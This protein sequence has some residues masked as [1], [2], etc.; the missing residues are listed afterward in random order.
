MKKFLLLVLDRNAYFLLAAAWLFT[1]AFIISNYYSGATSVGYLRS[2]MEARVRKQEERINKLMADTVQLKVLAEGSFTGQQ[3]AKL[4]KEEF[5]FF[6]YKPAEHE[7]WS[8]QFWSNQQAEPNTEIIFS[9]DSHHLVKLRNGQYEYIRRIIPL[10]RDSLLAIA[11]LPIRTEYF[12]Q[13]SAPEFMGFPQAE[14]NVSIR[15]SETSY[16]VRCANGQALFYLEQKRTLEVKNA[17]EWSLVLEILA[18]ALLMIVVHSIATSVSEQYGFKWGMLFLLAAILLARGTTYL[19][20]NH[21]MWK[22][23]GLFDPSVYSSNAF[24]PSLGDLVINAFLFCWLLLFFYRKG[25]SVSVARWKHTWL[26]WPVVAVIA[27]LMVLITFLFAGVVQSLIS[28]AQISFNV[29]NIFSLNGYS[30]VGFILL[31]VLA[32]SFSLATSILMRLVRPL[33]TEK[34]YLFYAA[35]ALFG[36][37]S[38]TFIGTNSLVE[39]NIYVLAWLIGYVWLM[40]QPKISVSTYRWSISVLLLWIFLYSVSIS[41]IIINENSRI[42]LDKRRG[43]AEKLSQQADPTSER[44]LSIALT[45]FDNDFL[46]SNFQRFRVSSANRYLKDSLIN[47][48]F[49]PYISKYDT[50]IYT[51]DEQEKPL[52]NEEP[53]SYDTLNTIFRIEGKPT[54]LAD[55]RYFEKSFDQFSYISRKMVTDSMG[56][57][58]GYVF[59]LS[60]PKKYKPDA[61]VPALFRARKDYLPDDYTP[62]Y[63]Y[64]IYNNRELIDYYNDYP[65][66]TKLGVNQVPKNSFTLTQHNGYDELWYRDDNKVVVIARRDNVLMESITLVAYLF[67]TFLLLLGL[68]RLASLLMRSRMRL[69]L[70]KK[71]LQMNLRAQ[72]H[73]TI[74]FISLFS[75]LV[76]GA[77]TIFFFI[78]RYNNNKQD[79]LSKAIKIMANEVQGKIESEVFLEWMIQLYAQGNNQVLEELVEEMSEIHGTDINIYDLRGVL[80]LSS[81]PFIYDKGILSARMNPTAFYEL[82]KQ[83]LVQVTTEEQMGGITYQ[84]IYSP[85][86]DD[87]GNAYAYLN[88]PS[89]DSQEELKKEISNFLVTIINLNAFIFLFA[90]VVALFITNRVTSSFSLISAKMRAVSLGQHN[91]AIEW[92][93]EDEIGELVTEYNKMV[94]KLEESAAALAKSERESAWREMARQVA[95]EIKNPL[96][97]MKLSIQYLQKAVNN[98]SGD[99]KQLTAN[100]ANTLVEQIDHLSRIASEFSQFANINNANVEVFDLH[101]ILYSLSHLYQSGGEV[102]FTWVPIS[103]PLM[104]AADR[105]QMNRLF[106]NLLKNAVEATDVDGQRLVRMEE[107]VTGSKV[108]ICITDNGHGIA[109]EMRSKIFAPNFTTK[110]SGTGLGLAMSKGIVEQAK[111]A[112]WFQTRQGEGSSFFVELPLV[113]EEIEE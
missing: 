107:E 43:T 46:L 21:V 15:E 56:H 13:T 70:I 54:N 7:A 30:V 49:S 77:A 102:D 23:Y 57:T 6:L 59:I 92:H 44:L 20:K 19:W 97:P 96:T 2:T 42:E 61:L 76:I 12:I 86:R 24:L 26:H 90:G 14:N 31:A 75:F 79:Q 10:A 93:R 85:V 63:S 112:I 88:M 73:S 71:E 94:L 53:V 11:L 65:F 67:T 60:E 52:F 82:G 87:K 104:V 45:Y 22:A 27:I 99:V 37:L 101:E 17:N 51:F 98:N 81:N 8:L 50:R 47:K 83:R 66:P 84:S 4:V 36:L 58:V 64:A 74:I 25:T 1:I 33:L 68:F 80:R 91:D 29:T 105:T 32:L 89:F 34:S 38:I 62:I 55:M 106:T 39:L 95:H 35:L 111:G 109:S 3:L 28:D 110:S 40:R 113:Q 78:N 9:N 41:L 18:V 69:P 103:G 48:N 100:V 16:P 108:V 72:V 5:G